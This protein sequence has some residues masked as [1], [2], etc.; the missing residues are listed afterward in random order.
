[1]PM[2]ERGSKVLLTLTHRRIAERSARLMIGAGWH[3]HLDIL[4]ARVSG[5]EPAM[6][7]WD[8]W[9]RLKQEYDRLLPA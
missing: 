5:E 3:A 6:P 8:G 7:F 2:E 4:V 9:K 1:M